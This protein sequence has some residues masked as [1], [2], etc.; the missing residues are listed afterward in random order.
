MKSVEFTVCLRHNPASAIYG[1]GWP[2]LYPFESSGRNLLWT[3]ILPRNRPADVNL[4]WS[5][6]T[7]RIRVCIN[8][9]SLRHSDVDFVRARVRWMFRANERFDAFWSACSHSNQLK[10]CAELKL[11]ALLRAPT[12][13][14]DLIKTICT[15]NC[16]WRNTKMMVRLFCER[17]GTP[18]P[19][20]RHRFS[21]PVHD[22][23]ARKSEAEL[24]KAKLGFRARYIKQLSEM[25][26]DR[27]IDLKSWTV[28]PDASALRQT[29][30]E[31]PGVGPYAAH[32][33]LMLLGHYEYIPCD[34]EVCA[35]L[36]LPANTSSSRVESIASERYRQWNRFAFLAY[37]FER[38]LSR[39]NYIDC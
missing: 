24:R 33:I 39:K 2:R 18:S 32:H 17:F 10:K 37:K 35:Y 27:E 36:K 15:V 21:F 3:M 23:I 9:L 14:E 6:R 7:F 38:V 25:I 29:L 8:A 26:R 11:G 12:L 19:I 5:D 22:V 20:S 31:L 34:S 1:H 16:H 30:L 13:F 28:N 4:R